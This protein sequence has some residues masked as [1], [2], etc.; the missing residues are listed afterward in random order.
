MVVLAAQLA[1]FL[2]R[3]AGHLTSLLVRKIL[4]CLA[5]WWDQLLTWKPAVQPAAHLA[6]LLVSPATCVIPRACCLTS[7]PGLFR[8]HS[9]LHL[10]YKQF[11]KEGGYAAYSKET[12][13]LWNFFSS[14]TWDSG[15]EITGASVRC[16]SLVKTSLPSLILLVEKEAFPFPDSATV[17]TTALF[18]LLLAV[19]VVLLLVLL[20][21]LARRV[22]CRLVMSG[23]M[24]PGTVSALDSPATR[25]GGYYFLQMAPQKRNWKGWTGRC[26]F[27]FVMCKTEWQLFKGTGPRGS[28]LYL[29]LLI[30]AKNFEF[31][32]LSQSL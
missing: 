17:P 6:S 11:I 18:W 1:G 28:Y 3:P 22:A 10:I 15:G 12:K 23:M 16:R 31:Y 7:Q 27:S 13:Q 9:Q 14:E 20:L 19:E 26:F 32:L 29:E 25:N 30:F 2:G 5:S 4:T 24:L 8:M 21:V